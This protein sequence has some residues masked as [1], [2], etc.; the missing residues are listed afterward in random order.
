MAPLPEFEQLVTLAERDPEAFEKMRQTACQQFIATVP[1]AH[2]QRLT[3]VQHRVEMEIRRAKTPLA[4]LLKVSCMMHDSLYE[5][6]SKWIE[7]NRFAHRPFN[8]TQTQPSSRAEIINFQDWKVR[9]QKHQ[10]NPH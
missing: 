9:S 6:T 1:K 10:S 5:L 2:R 3:A 8:P 7:F 4:G